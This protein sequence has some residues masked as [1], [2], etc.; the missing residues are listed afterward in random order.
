MP[1]SRTASTQ[2]AVRRRA[3]AR[4]RSTHDLAALGELHGVAEQVDQHLA[5]PGDVADDAPAARRRRAGTARSRPLAPACAATRSSEPSTQ[6]RTENGSVLELELAGLDLGEVEDVVD[7]DEQGVAAGADRLGEVALL[8]RQVGVEQQPGHP[9]HGVHRRAD[10]VRHGREERRLGLRWPPRPRARA[11]DQVALA[12]A[13]PAAARARSASAMLAQPV[14]DRRAARPGRRPAAGPSRSPVA[15]PVDRRRR[16]PSTGV[17]DVG[18][19]P[20]E[21]AGAAAARPRRAAGPRSTSDGEHQHAATCRSLGAC[22]QRVRRA[23]GRA[24]R[25]RGS[26]RTAPCPGAGTPAASVP[27]RAALPSAGRP[28]RSSQARCARLELVE[29]ARA[30]RLVAGEARGARRRC[31]RRAPPRRARTGSRNAVVAGEQ[32]AAQPGLLVEHRQVRQPDRAGA[33]AV[34]RRSRGAWTVTS[35]GEHE[36]ADAVAAPSA[37][38]PRG[39]AERRARSGSAAART[40]RTSRATA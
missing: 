5:Q 31:A 16:R 22:A 11:R 32:E 12:L 40:P 39:T 26:R 37:A 33:V 35:S 24:P 1:V 13:R 28:S 4:R 18:A 2:R 36:G 15:Q 14:A 9:D 29:P 38:A 6:S 3:P 7:D 8:G 34:A 23:L 20:H 10:L 21:L 19:Q 17:D 25:P 30:A 27:V